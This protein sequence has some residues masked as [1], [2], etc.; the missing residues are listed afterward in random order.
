[1]KPKLPTTS[2]DLIT[3]NALTRQGFLDQAL[4]KIAIADEFV[5]QA[6]HL[7]DELSKAKDPN[8]AVNNQEI[9]S[10]LVASVGFSQKASNY[11][12]APELRTALFQSIQTVQSLAGEDWRES[13][14]YRFLLTKGDS[15]GGRLRNE[16]GESARVKFIQTVITKLESKG[17]SPKQT[18]SPSNS[19][20]IQKLDWPN[21]ILLFDKRSKLIGKSIDVILLRSTKKNMSDSERLLRPNDYLACGEIK[22]GIDPAGADEHWK[23][24]KGSLDTIRKQ[25]PRKTLKLFFVGAAIE[26]SMADEIISQFKTGE[27]A[28]A[29]NLTDSGKVSDLAEWLVSL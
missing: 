19:L 26:K 15:I 10:E 16:I 8:E 11:F 20:K 21:R 2:D 14:V 3:T 9:R 24:T 4:R 29:A 13:L 7:L 1:M 17:I 22:G 23:T 25:I 18:S 12:T 27:L 6:V 28:H 5:G